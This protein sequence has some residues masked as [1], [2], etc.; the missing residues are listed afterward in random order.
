ME[1][2]IKLSVIFAVILSASIFSSCATQKNVERTESII[3]G[4]YV[5][6]DTLVKGPLL[7][8]LEKMKKIQWLTSDEIVLV[9]SYEIHKDTI[10]DGVYK[11][12]IIQVD[13]VK[14]PKFA[15]GI[16]I[17]NFKLT[18]EVDSLNIGF[19]KASNDQYSPYI[20]DASEHNIKYG[21]HVWQI[22]KGEEVKLL[23]DIKKSEKVKTVRVIKGMKLGAKSVTLVQQQPVKKNDTVI[24]PPEVTPPPVVEEKTK[25]GIIFK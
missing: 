4:H 6:T 2:T 14:F 25:S 21:S 15:Q 16:M 23:F 19:K 24:T 3:D 13:T 20:L 18:F 11:T 7:N 22:T 1:T 10:V 5:L 12:N 17:S 8:S 9:R